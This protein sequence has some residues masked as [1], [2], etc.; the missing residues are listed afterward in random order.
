MKRRTITRKHAPN[1]VEQVEARLSTLTDE[2]EALEA[3]YNAS[4]DEDERYDI[5]LEMVHIKEEIEGCESYLY[6]KEI[7]GLTRQYYHDCI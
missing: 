3:R 7:E 5:E 2:L 4:N 1:K 6:N